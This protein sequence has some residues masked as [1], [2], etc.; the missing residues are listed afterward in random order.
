MRTLVIL[1]TFF[2][3]VHAEAQRKIL[4]RFVNDSLHPMK[5]EV[6]GKSHFFYRIMYF[7]KLPHPRYAVE[8]PV[9][10]PLDEICQYKHEK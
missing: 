4:K 10:V 9:N 6:S 7:M 5:T 1:L 2:I 8:E 3:V